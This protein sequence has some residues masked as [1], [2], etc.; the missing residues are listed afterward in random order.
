[1]VSS[2]CCSNIWMMLNTFA[3]ARCM[4]NFLRTLLTSFSEGNIACCAYE[5]EWS[6]FGWLKSKVHLQPWWRTCTKEPP[7]KSTNVWW[8]VLVIDGRCTN[9][10]L[11]SY[12]SNMPA[13]WYMSYTFILY[14]ILYY[15]IHKIY[16]IILLGSVYDIFFSIYCVYIYIFIY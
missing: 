4:T 15:H 14:I 16:I 12:H 9:L 5:A 11:R 7:N 8:I 1:M 6:T 10:D 13:T 3:Y 2:G